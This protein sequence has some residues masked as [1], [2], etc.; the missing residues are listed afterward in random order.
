M[1][2]KEILLA[3]NNRHK[4][5][6]IK[7]LLHIRGL[8]VLCLED[9]PGRLVVK[10][11]GRTFAQNAVKKAVAAARKFGIAS[12]SDDSGLCVDALSGGPGVRSARFVKP[13]VTSEKLCRKLLL[14]MK[15]M[16]KGK[17]GARFVCCVALAYPS[18]KTVT[19]E[20]SC[21]GTIG[22]E[23]RGAKGFGYDPV[24]ILKGM[25]RTFAQISAKQKNLISHRGKA[26]RKIRKELMKNAV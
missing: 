7:K 22:P 9:M 19:V 13:P 10:E 1:R 14:K 11:N 26:F 18:G 5:A 23:M 24:F 4:V 20:G 12:V 17:R 21:C 15:N 25:D 8:K 6:E 3:T 16:P 2:L